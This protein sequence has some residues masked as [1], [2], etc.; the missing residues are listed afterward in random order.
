MNRTQIDEVIF[1][2]LKCIAP[3]SEPSRL[4]PDENI[5]RMLGIDSFDALN[6]FI[7]LNEELGVDIPESDYG[8]LNTLAEI[9][10]YLSDRLD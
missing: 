6:F 4:E 3:E 1:R 5:R 9:R 8:Q 10:R 2:Q 7:R